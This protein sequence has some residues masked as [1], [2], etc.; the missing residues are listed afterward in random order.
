MVGLPAP[1]LDDDIRDIIQV[2][3]PG[4]ASFLERHEW[5]KHGTCHRAAGGAD[6]YFDDMLGVTDAI[7]ASEV[8]AL[9]AGHVGGTVRTADIRA[10]FDAA[11]GPGAGERVQVHC[12][13]D[14]GRTLVQELKINLKGAITPQTP[15]GELML[16]ADPTSP[17]CPEG[18]IDPA[19]LQ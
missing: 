17:G 4:T 11:F 7:N 3:M 12:T 14:G 15:L 18:V 10:A 16:A 6:A 9:L 5:L 13:G 2:A 1:Q 19:G 8:G